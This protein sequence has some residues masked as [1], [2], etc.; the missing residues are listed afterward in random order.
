M[1]PI[2]NKSIREIVYLFKPANTALTNLLYAQYPEWILQQD[3]LINLLE[4]LNYCK[5]I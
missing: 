4:N 2:W 5:K 1:S 3:L